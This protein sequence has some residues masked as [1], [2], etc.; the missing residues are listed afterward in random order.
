[1][2]QQYMAKLR[3][4]QGWHSPIWIANKTGGYN[5]NLNSP[6]HQCRDD[7]G[8]RDGRQW[9]SLSVAATSSSIGIELSG[10]SAR[11]A[12]TSLSQLIASA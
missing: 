9:L 7:I 4:P 10:S 5:R 11:S 8:V 2:L 12:S 3:S 1:M 6:Q